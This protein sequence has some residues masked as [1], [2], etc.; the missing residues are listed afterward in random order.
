MFIR[1]NLWFQINYLFVSSEIKE[2][3][4]RILKMLVEKKLGGVLIN[5][6]HNFSWITAGA[7]N[8]IDLSRENGAASILIRNDGKKFVLAN[9]IEMPR[10]L[11][12][13]ISNEDFESIDFAW[14]DEKS[15]SDFLTNRAL[16]LLKNGEKIGADLFINAATPIIEGDIARCRYE[17]TD[18]E[19][20]RFRALG[21]DAGETLG[22]LIITLQIGD[23]EIEIARKTKDALAAKNI[24]SVVT[25]VATDER[26][27]KFRHPVPT[28]KCWKK[29]L[30]IVVC[31]KRQG[32]IASLS[33]II[34]DGKIPAELRKRT[35]ACARVNAKILA[36]TKQGATSAGLYK[37][38]ADAYAAENFAGE[39]KLHHQGGASGYKTRD[40]VAHPNSSEVV[41]NNQAFAWNP[42]ITGTK[43]EET[44]IV[45]E[46]GIEIITATPNFPQI[47]VEIEGREYLS[48][49]IL[50]L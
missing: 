12:E 29:V 34:C 47:T 19:I 16:S 40:W 35:D 17:L 18:A 46:S 10:M 43:T 23:S 14:E 25:L 3:T 33:R 21:K 5:S 27:Q 39:E 2:K 50:S 36:A 7:N 24:Y 11:D 45:R 9:R 8:G 38:A 31:T 32:L 49:D 22:E 30:M 28:E 4:E 37:I 20:E 48:P 26:I 1:E 42:S 41:Q 13:E 44:V 15:S 6:Q